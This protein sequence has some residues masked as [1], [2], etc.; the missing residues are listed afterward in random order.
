MCV[1][2][3]HH[4]K[5]RNKP[6]FQGEPRVTV[7]GCAPRFGLPRR[8]V[9][10]RFEMGEHR[11]IRQHA[12]NIGFNLVEQFVTRPLHGPMARNEHV[13]GYEISARRPGVSAGREIVCRIARRFAEPART[14]GHVRG[15][16]ATSIKPPTE[17]R[18]ICTPVQ[19][20]LAATA[21][22]TTGSS[23]CQGSGDD[24][25][26]AR[27]TRTGRL[28]REVHTS[29]QDKMMRIGFKRDRIVPATAQ[30]N[31]NSATPKLIRESHD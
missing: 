20:I 16:S 14:S 5:R 2:L 9:I 18:T 22:A 15:G 25:C 21:N 3:N 1:E 6:G 12:A 23:Q 19:T 7:A 13:R 29:V 27:H 28:F 10:Q 26:H 31:S 30:S 4:S 24:Q 8:R 11:C 17:R